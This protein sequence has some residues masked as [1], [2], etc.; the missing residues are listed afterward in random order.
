MNQSEVTDTTD[1]VAPM[2]TAEE[3]AQPNFLTTIIIVFFRKQGSRPWMQL[4]FT[5]YIICTLSLSASKR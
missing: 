4:L 3:I 2:M 5:L 1:Y